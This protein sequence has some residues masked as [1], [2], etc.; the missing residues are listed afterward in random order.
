MDSI[1]AAII[2]AI[3]LI[4]LAIAG[5]AARRVRE[6]RDKRGVRLRLRVECAENIKTLNEFWQQVDSSQFW[7]QGTGYSHEEI[8]F[9]KRR[10]L[11]SVPLPAWSHLM[12]ERQAEAAR[13]DLSEEE[14]ENAL[15]L[16]TDL[17][18]FS[19]MR[20]KLQE[21]LATDTN[22]KLSRDFDDWMLQK[23]RGRALN[24]R[25]ALERS[26]FAALSAFNAST[27]PCWAECS[28]IHNRAGR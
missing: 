3:V 10:R 1:F 7:V 19:D 6:Q 2:G 8:E 28:V 23:A 21:A 13:L 25:D 26:M 9:H 18:M 16:H 4:G 22:S 24:G 12:W 5:W 17:D 15:R 11:A 27:E 20:A 14:F